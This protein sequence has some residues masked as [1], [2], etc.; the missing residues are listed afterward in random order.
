MKTLI[1][2]VLCMATIVACSTK[3]SC[4]D[5]DC[6][7]D[8]CCK[9]SCCEES[10][11]KES[12][13][14]ESCCKE[15]CCE[16]TSCSNAAEAA[17][18]PINHAEYKTQNDSVMNEVCE[19]L[20]NCGVYYIATVEGNQ[21]RVRPFGTQSIYEGKLYIM[22]GHKK[23][24]AKQIAANPKVEICAY[25]GKGEWLRVSA[26]L[27]DD[28]RVEAKQALIDLNPSLASMYSATDPN[29]AIYYLTNAEATFSSF[30][31]GERKVKF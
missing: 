24:V 27:V 11:C 25:D 8:S 22:S 2:S 6:C 18:Q 14:K 28:E 26:T 30:A 10:C 20:K 7:K 3:N 4:C 12:C 19:F 1:F 23:N 5:K 15:S 29:T 31:G 13:C 16:K 21:P 17:Q 9:E